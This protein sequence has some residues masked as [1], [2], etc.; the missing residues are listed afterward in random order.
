MTPAHINVADILGDLGALDPGQA[1][2][3][4][5]SVI[6]T[7]KSG[8]RVTV[9]FEGTGVVS[10]AF[11]NEFFLALAETASLYVWRVRVEFSGIGASQGMVLGK[12]L[13]AVR[14]RLRTSTNP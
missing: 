7:S 11:A 10:S 6:E 12:S 9:N 4:A 1:R 8:L 5:R 2:V 14:A 3:L 13:K